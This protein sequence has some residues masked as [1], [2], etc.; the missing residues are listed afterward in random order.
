M[1]IYKTTIILCDLVYEYPLLYVYFMP[2]CNPAFPEHII[3]I[4]L[5][6]LLLR[7]GLI[8]SYKK[9]TSNH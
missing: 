2:L 5:P 3:S 9:W 6:Y 7:K 1:H 4:T 8:C